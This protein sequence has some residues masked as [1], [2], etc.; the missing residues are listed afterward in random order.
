VVVSRPSAPRSVCRE[1]PMVA[2]GQIPNT[3]HPPST[4]TTTFTDAQIVHHSAH[5]VVPNWSQAMRALTSTTT[6]TA[7]VAYMIRQEIASAYLFR[8][9]VCK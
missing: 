8:I 3:A 2:S 6:R 5:H 4:P 1:R 9:A 7:S